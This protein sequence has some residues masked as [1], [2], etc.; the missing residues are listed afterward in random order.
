M[1]LRN[2][3]PWVF[4]LAYLKMSS[5][6][7]AGQSDG[8]GNQV[9][10][11]EDF[12]GD[13]IKTKSPHCNNL[14]NK[15]K[16]LGRFNKSLTKL[17]SCFSK[18]DFAAANSSCLA[19]LSDEKVSLKGIN[20]DRKGEYWCYPSIRCRNCSTLSTN[21]QKCKN[22]LGKLEKNCLL[23]QN[24]TGTEIPNNLGYALI[25]FLPWNCEI[26]NNFKEKMDLLLRLYNINR[27]LPLYCG[28]LICNETKS[29]FPIP[30]LRLNEPTHHACSNTLTELQTNPTCYREK[31]EFCFYAFKGPSNSNSIVFISKD[32][33]MISDT[34]KLVYILRNFTDF[35]SN[36]RC[37]YPLNYIKKST[38][39]FLYEKTYFFCYTKSNN[40]ND[41]D[42]WH[43]RKITETARLVELNEN[44]TDSI[45]SN[46]ILQRL[47][48]AETNISIKTYKT[49]INLNYTFKHYTNEFHIPVFTANHTKIET[50]EDIINENMNITNNQYFTKVEDT[51]SIWGHRNWI[52]FYNCSL[53]Y[54]EDSKD[55]LL[56]IYNG[57][58][59]Y[60]YICNDDTGVLLTSIRR[61]N[62]TLLQ[63]H[64]FFRGCRDQG[65][66]KQ[67][68]EDC[69]RDLETAT[70]YETRFFHFLV[71][72]KNMDKS[73][74]KL[75]GEK[76]NDKE[77]RIFEKEFKDNTHPSVVGGLTKILKNETNSGDFDTKG[78]TESRQKTLQIF[79]LASLS[80]NTECVKT[81]V[82]GSF[83]IDINPNGTTENL[84]PVPKYVI[85]PIPFDITAEMCL[86]ILPI[87][88]NEDLLRIQNNTMLRVNKF[89]PTCMYNKL[90][91]WNENTNATKVVPEWDYLPLPCKAMEM[92]LFLLCCAITFITISG[93]IIVITVMT[94][95][96]L[97]KK[98]VYMIYTSVAAADLL[99]GVTTASLALRDTYDLMN[100]YLTIYD[101]SDDGPWAPFGTFA[102]YQ[103]K[104]FQQTRFPRYGWP[105]Y[106]AIAMNISILSSLMSLALLGILILPLSIKILTFENLRNEEKDESQRQ[107]QNLNQSNSNQCDNFKRW[108]FYFDNNKTIKIGICI[109]WVWNIILAFLINAGSNLQENSDNKPQDYTLTGFF[110]PVTKLTLNTGRGKSNLSSTAFY[111]QTL[112]AS[113]AGVIIVAILTTLAIIF[114]IRRSRVP[115]NITSNNHLQHVKHFS[116]ISRSFMLMVILFLIS[117]A[118]I[119]SVILANSVTVNISENFPLLHFIIWWLCMAGSSWNW[120]IYCFRR[121]YFK[122]EA[123]KLLQKLCDSV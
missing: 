90:I 12:E 92:G 66:N 80:N 33:K 4:M 95:S 84:Q 115:S 120:L 38:H 49:I 79:I 98:H 123:K 32:T 9:E 47:I 14:N 112:V 111:L 42:L 57:T 94:F 86:K 24:F 114:S 101:L 122:D 64:N 34:E 54:Q 52:T 6:P 102:N 93:N 73:A 108:L 31:N 20:S 41:K 29:A 60:E 1:K 28:H 70:D 75:L 30:I 110:D 91:A 116:A 53:K 99:L 15:E 3:W 27:K 13:F 22:N 88:V 37:E 121:R 106:C 23:T 56:F 36:E 100:G 82:E 96:G 87:D 50:L 7:T 71:Y 109:I 55:L 107:T 85:G 46:V 19:F 45:K 26:G 17:E 35:Q 5:Y 40:Y 48:F 8:G 11:Q 10:S 18:N 103:P 65:I 68:D 83:S 118:P 61:E 2:P 51:V 76:I 16:L 63:S 59:D 105:A 72:P 119:A 44:V 25:P 77:T 58:L 39:N 78:Q 97:V 117:C 69:K 43:I 104:G 81:L 67:T 74:V 113:V 21:F 62:V 89:W